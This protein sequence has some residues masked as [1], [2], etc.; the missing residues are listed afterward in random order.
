MD[1]LIAEFLEETNES[2][3]VVDEQ[4]VTFEKTPDDKEILGNIFR[5]V[6]TIKG[7]CG[8]LGLSRLEKVAHAG[9][10]LIGKF[11]D[12]AIV[13]AQAVTIVLQGLDRIKYIVAE[14]Q[15]TGKEPEGNDNELIDT[16]NTMAKKSLLPG[17]EADVPT[18]KKTKKTSKKKQ[19]KEQGNETVKKTETTIVED[20]EE[21]SQDIS[22]EELERIWNETEVDEQIV[23]KN[24]N[25]K[26]NELQDKEQIETPSSEQKEKPPVNFVQESQ[27]KIQEEISRQNDEAKAKPEPQRA[28]AESI[29]MQ[30][31]IRVNVATLENLMNTVSELVLTRNQLQDM[32]RKEQDTIFKAPVQ[33]LSNV[34]ADLQEN[35]MKT[36]MQPIGNA[37]QKLPRIVRDL[38]RELNK[39]VNLQMNGS[40]TE[41]DR[42]VLEMIR[43]PLTH[44]VRNS[45]DHGLETTQ[46]RKDLGKSETGQIVLSAYHQGGYII[47]E[48]SDDGKGLDLG[49]IKQKCLELELI[50]PDE[51]EKMTEKQ[52]AT[53]IFR[54]GFSTAEKVTNVSG[55][56]VG[57]DVV[58]NNIELIGGIIDLSTQKGEGS[59]FTIKIPLTLAIVSALI[60]GVKGEHFAIP[61]LSVVELV[62]VNENTNSYIEKINH[63]PVLRLRDKLLPL[64]HLKDLLVL[65]NDEKDIH[66][67]TSEKSSAM[68]EESVNKRKNIDVVNTETEINKNDFI[69][70][71][72]VGD[73]VFGIVVDHVFDTEEIVVKPVANILRNISIYSGITILGSGT[74]IMILD[75]NGISQAFG[76]NNSNTEN[77]AEKA[78]DQNQRAVLTN[79]MLLFYKD[80]KK[81]M[82]MA[83]PLELITRLEEI[84]TEN[85]EYSVD[86]AVVK[87][88]GKLMPLIFLSNDDDMKAGIIN[89][90]VFTR[91]EFSV[92]FVVSEIIDIIDENLNIE[93]HAEENGIL[94]TAIFLGNATEVLDVGYYLN[95]DFS[96]WFLSTERDL[97]SYKNVLGSLLLV[98]DSSF[99][100]NM[101]TPVLKAAGYDV[102]TAKSGEEALHIIETYQEFDL[103]ITDIEM[104]NMNG[105]ELT[106]KLRKIPKYREKSIFALTG[107][108]TSESIQRGHQSG[109]DNYIAK[110]DREGLL[111]LLKIFFTENKAA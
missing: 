22:L 68:T 106:E 82:P 53:L 32:V 80:R 76:E 97:N 58:R 16:I 61:Q 27:Q 38:S 107:D 75:P 1:E 37:W 57:M 98:D 88:R 91:G 55:R 23:N 20:D 103:V 109:F 14:I 24:V 73:K 6:H 10:N 67:Q 101:L 26:G 18:E 15:K 52:I 12:G 49:R 29:G 74:V 104:P 45:V 5:L 78:S 11:R 95:K 4:L 70:V 31:T 43:D 9:E 50:K 100:L 3:D 28:T 93:M 105:F 110:F 46:M 90:L 33:R 13:T 63:A 87:Y 84:K 77:Y 69:V 35:I 92:G 96:K 34:T 36:R 42:Q 17:Q 51:L 8:F 40:E 59:K 21:Q 25:V 48:L 79:S 56:G 81:R 54:P 108:Y 71:M 44:M 111:E 60:V 72:H 39:K 85:I 66:S 94:G 64:L 30:Q 83:V 102:V 19:E 86:R 47:I 65:N 62:R 89:V 2:L 41:L 7:T 99:F